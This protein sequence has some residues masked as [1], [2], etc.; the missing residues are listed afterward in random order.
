M[1]VGEVVLRRQ[2]GALLQRDDF[3]PGLRQVVGHDPGHE[4]TADG[5]DV[6]FL[7]LCHSLASS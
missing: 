2:P 6:D 3:E 7:V 5:D 1:I 4:T